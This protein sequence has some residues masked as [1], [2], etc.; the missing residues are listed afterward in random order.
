MVAN[1]TPEN[2]SLHSWSM[3]S[4]RMLPFEFALCLPHKVCQPFFCFFFIFWVVGTLVILSMAAA[5]GPAYPR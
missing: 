1:A 2:V 5:F 3:R 4:L